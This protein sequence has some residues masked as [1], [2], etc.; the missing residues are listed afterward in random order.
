MGVG[1]LISE[2]MMNPGGGQD[3]GVR[4]S[5]SVMNPGAAQDQGVRISESVM[6][7]GLVQSRNHNNI[8]IDRKSS[9]IR[10]HPDCTNCASSSATSC[11]NCMS[12]QAVTH[13]RLQEPILIPL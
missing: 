11:P 10:T 6:S 12:N 1:I 5:E 8:M 7:T 2:S 3:H 9:L 13:K 4:I